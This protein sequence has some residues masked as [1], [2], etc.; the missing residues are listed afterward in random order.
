M[1]PEHNG[2]V[3]VQFDFTGVKPGHHLLM[4]DGKSAF[5][6]TEYDEE[7]GIVT[8][9]VEGDEPV[10]FGKK[11]GLNL[12]DTSFPAGYISEDQARLP[13]SFVAIRYTLLACELCTGPHDLIAMKR[14]M[15]AWNIHA[16]RGAK[17]EDKTGNRGND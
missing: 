1:G 17:V 4:H 12:P 11:Q 16:K 15:D 6:I 2:I 8:A 3:P 14:D 13:F 7:R 5:L 10:T 9:E